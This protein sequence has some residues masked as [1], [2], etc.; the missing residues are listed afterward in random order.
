MVFPSTAMKALWLVQ[1]FS[2]AV[3][4]LTPLFCQISQNHP[5]L[6][7]DRDRPAAVPPDLSATINKSNGTAA[8]R[9]GRN[10]AV[11]LQGVNDEIL[12]VC[13]MASNKLVVF[14]STDVGYEVNSIDTRRYVVSDSFAAYAPLMS[15]NQQWIAYR[16][17][18]APQSEI[19]ISEEYLLYDLNASASAN[20]HNLTAYTIDA[21]GWAMY[22]AV[23]RN[24][25]ANLL[26]IPQSEG[27]DWRSRSFFWGPIHQVHTQVHT[28]R[29][30]QCC[31]NVR[32]FR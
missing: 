9:F 6:C 31:G 8:L 21:I 1:T 23:P 12:E 22:P 5:D 14:G 19:K 16:H 4:S 15:P 7:G 25:P 3:W 26:D 17:F 18:S 29:C 28:R 27:H 20:R 24:A 2:F 10:H 32:R 11:A 30:S 13:P